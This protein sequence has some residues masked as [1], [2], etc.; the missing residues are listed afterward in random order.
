MLFIC[1]NVF[2]RI[3]RWRMGCGKPEQEHVP[4]LGSGRERPWAHNGPSGRLNESFLYFPFIL[5]WCLSSTCTRSIRRTAT[6]PCP[7]IRVCRRQQQGKWDF[8]LSLLWQST[9]HPWINPQNLCWVPRRLGIDRS[10]Y[11]TRGRPKGTLGDGLVMRLQGLLKNN[12]V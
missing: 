8:V 4:G 12:D 7:R 1:N 9:S 11:T 6:G 2:R 5:I 3:L 10:Y